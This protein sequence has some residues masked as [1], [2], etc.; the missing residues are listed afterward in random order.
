M[1]PPTGSVPARAA[2]RKALG[3]RFAWVTSTVFGKQVDLVYDFLLR[4]AMPMSRP[5]HEV[6]AEAVL[7]G[8]EETA[9]R[10]GEPDTA[11]RRPG[12]VLPGRRPP[13]RSPAPVAR[14]VSDQD[15]EVL[16]LRFEAAAGAE[17]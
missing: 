7:R 17:E 15:P 16:Q 4:Q 5:W 11:P 1:A 10:R 6:E 8:L 13:T 14:V 2:E 12:D 3:P 9:R